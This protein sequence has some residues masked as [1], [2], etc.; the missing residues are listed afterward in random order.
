LKRGQ[1][2]CGTV[3]KRECQ[4][5][6]V[7]QFDLAPMFIEPDAVCVSVISDWKQD[8]NSNLCKYVCVFAYVLLECTQLYAINKF[9]IHIVRQ[10]KK[11]TKQLPR[12]HVIPNEYSQEQF[13]LGS[14]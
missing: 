13:P 11:M 12:H 9:A 3:A 6:R 2:N 4:H 5:K 1:K 10:S 14:F 8:T 7:L